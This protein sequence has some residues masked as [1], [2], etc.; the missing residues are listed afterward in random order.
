MSHNDII[1]PSSVPILIAE[2]NRTQAEYLR[3][4]LEKEGYPVMLSTNGK[5]AL[6][7]VIQTVP[8]LS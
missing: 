2:D 4:I 6:N 5:E 3:Y 1:Q 8:G 7:L